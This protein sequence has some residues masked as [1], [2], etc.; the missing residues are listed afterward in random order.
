MYA[1]Y[2]FLTPSIRKPSLRAQVIA[3]I[4]FVATQS[5]GAP[6]VAADRPAEFKKLNA[7]YEAANKA[8]FEARQSKKNP[9]AADNI[10]NYE[11][12]PAWQY[13]PRFV[14]LADDNPTDETAVQCC[15]WVRKLTGSV[16]TSDRAVFTADNRAW[17]ILATYHDKAD[18]LPQL[19]LDATAYIGP[20]REKFLRH[21]LQKKDTAKE[22]A[23]FATLAL[24]ELLDHTRDNVDFAE[25]DRKRPKTDE[26][27]KYIKGRHAPEFDEYVAKHSAAELRAESLKLYRDVLMHYADVPCSA[28]N[29]H[30]RRAATLG[31]AATQA[32]YALEHLSA[33]AEA[34]EIVG[35]DLNG[36]PLKLSDY[37]GRVVVLSFWFTG[38][39][40]CME[41]IP[42]ERKLVDS[43]KDQPF[44]L[45]GICG[46][47][48]LETGLKTAK[49]EHVTWP[50]WFDG[51]NV[52]G[53]INRLYS[54][55][56]WPTF[57]LIDKTG[58]IAI[59][60]MDRDYLA[61]D[62]AELLAKK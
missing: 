52:T 25:R 39:G 37:R 60:D 10:H 47:T 50:C 54:V 2:T 30:F 8:Y 3:L 44:A 14:T 51:G 41:M 23:A 27:T 49:D 26:F 53:P 62:V 38:C 40:P 12:W 32:M 48:K 57:Y 24:A 28:R 31:A 11:A 55:S 58:H 43:L 36:K 19:C 34:P 6:P 16:G 46:D 5:F 33:G 15:E 29:P 45:L 56:G 18:N 4:F 59:K 20:G 1:H 7:E 21:I 35:T 17:Q 61:D 9:T 13:L 42:K 22:N